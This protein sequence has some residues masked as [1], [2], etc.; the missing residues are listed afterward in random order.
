LAHVEAIREA[1]AELA[2][3]TRRGGYML[4][5]F[6][7]TLSLRY[8]IKR[9]KPAHAISD[10]VKDT[11]VFTRYDDLAAVRSYLPPRCH[12]VTLRGV[13]IVTLT[14]ALHRLPTVGPLLGKVERSVADAPLLRRLGGFLIVVAQKS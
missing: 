3:V 7:N 14:A 4:L 12:I 2:R 1:L 11:A 5:E 13:R 6:Y 9:L 10:S 8:L